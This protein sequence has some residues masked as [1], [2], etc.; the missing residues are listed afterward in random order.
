[1]RMRMKVVLGAV[2]ALAA[3]GVI[4]TAALATPPSGPPSLPATF[5]TTPG[6]VTGT[7]DGP[8]RAKNDGIELRTNRDV[9][10]TTFELNYPAGSVSGWHK[11]PGIVIAVVRSGAVWRQVGCTAPKFS[12]GESFTEV[13]PHYVSNVVTDKAARIR[14]RPWRSPRSTRRT[15]TRPSFASTSLRRAARTGS[16]TSNSPRPLWKP[17]IVETAHCGNRPFSGGGSRWPAAGSQTSLL[18]PRRISGWLR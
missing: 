12:Q 15:P 13:A 10:V 16:T 9:N 14:P 8:T 2:I 4:G 3:S 5:R 18:L 7:L 17:P 11:H 1:M 6:A